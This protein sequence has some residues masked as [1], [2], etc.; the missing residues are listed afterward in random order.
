MHNPSS[1]TPSIIPLLNTDGPASSDSPTPTQQRPW[2][3][4]FNNTKYHQLG[5]RESGIEMDN[6]LVETRSTTS[7]EST[8]NEEPKYKWTKRVRIAAGAAIAVLIINIILTVIA[9]GIAY[10]KF[11]GQQFGFAVIYRGSCKLSNNWTTGLHLLINILSTIA[12]AASNNCMQCL[13][14]P[15]REEIDR[16][17]GQY[18][19]LHVGTASLQNLWFIPAKRRCLWFILF[20]TSLPFHN[21]Y[22]SAVFSSD[23]LNSFEFGLATADSDLTNMSV[24]N[25]SCFEQAVGQGMSDS[26]HGGFEYLDHETCTRTIQSAMHETRAD[27]VAC[28]PSQGMI[29]VLSDD[30]AGINHSVIYR[31]QTV[32]TNG[33]GAV[34]SQPLPWEIPIWGV[35]IP[36]PNGTVTVAPYEYRVLYKPLAGSDAELHNDMETLADYLGYMTS[37][38][39]AAEGKDLQ[40]FLD[41]STNWQ[42]ASWAS[43]VSLRKESVCTGYTGITTHKWNPY[44][45]AGCLSQKVPEKCEL[46]FSLPFCL[47]IIACNAIKVMCMLLAVSDDRL[48]VIL[49]VGD[50]IASFLTHPDPTTKGRCL[51][52]ISSVR[53]GPQLWKEERWLPWKPSRASSAIANQSAK[54]YAD[55]LPEKKIRWHRAAGSSQWGVTITL[56][57]LCLGTSGILYWVIFEGSVYQEWW[58]PSLWHRNIDSI[59]ALVRRYGSPLPVLLFANTP[60]LL[61]STLY[62]LYNNLLTHMLLVAEYADYAC[63]RKSLRV[64]FPK[65]SQRSTYYLTIPYRYSVPL[66]IGSAL[67]HWLLSQSIYYSRVLHYDKFGNPS[68]TPVTDGAYFKG[69]PVL[70][71]IGFLIMMLVFAVTLGFRR[72]KG[73]LPLAGNCSA[74][75]SAACHPPEDD[76]DAALKKVMWG[77]VDMSSDTVSEPEYHHCSFTSYEVVTPCPTRLYS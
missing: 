44:H 11:D 58:M 63:H 34:D 42:N 27:C 47:V 43:S 72:L 26:T 45:L 13:S 64:S 7:H 76:R 60:Q 5:S 18:T 59:P 65:G 22:N 69:L 4:P 66:L 77:E 17:H 3:R 70:F 10:S 41:N 20:L 30:I 53:Q 15:S 52:S 68:A 55:R 40:A 73:N 12:L 51:M 6:G 56:I 19:W 24:D 49:T 37:P 35:D 75:I 23:N 31:L 46:L 14:A 2:R 54:G 9:S 62:L 25:E 16:A 71:F 39:E 28:A 32:D 38:R 48:D 29:I 61:M 36:V 74:A 21:I 67:A 1:S 8:T 33:D 57:L 50:A